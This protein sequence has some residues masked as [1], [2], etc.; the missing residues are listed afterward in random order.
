MRVQSLSWEDLLE[1]EIATHSSILAILPMGKSHGQRSLVGYSPQCCKELDMTEATQHARALQIYRGFP[2]CVI[3]SAGI[4]DIIQRR[5]FP[6][7]YVKAFRCLWFSPDVHK[8]PH[9][10]NRSEDRLALSH[11]NSL[12]LEFRNPCTSFPFYPPFIAYPASPCLL[13]VLSS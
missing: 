6:W 10:L 3:V 11:W 13:P 12:T 1:E 8:V 5:I 4:W 7:L 2:S 9:H